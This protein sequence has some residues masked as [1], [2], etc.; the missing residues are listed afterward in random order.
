MYVPESVDQLLQ[1]TDAAVVASVKTVLYTAGIPVGAPI[2]GDGQ[3]VAVPP[4]APLPEQPD[5][6]LALTILDVVAGALPAGPIIAY[7]IRERDFLTETDGAE[8]WR[9]F[10]HQ[11]ESGRWRIFAAYP[12]AAVG[13]MRAQLQAHA[14]AV[15]KG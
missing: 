5:Q 6:I 4:G 7:K 10:L 8:R 2:D 3:P 9:L 15:S 12:P 14:E 11:E 13:D 1:R